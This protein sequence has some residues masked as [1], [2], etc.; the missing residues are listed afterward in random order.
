[1]AAALAY[2]AFNMWTVEQLKSMGMT[3]ARA[4]EIDARGGTEPVDRLIVNY[5]RRSNIKVPA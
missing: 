2:Q 1:M 3:L 4:N 5:L